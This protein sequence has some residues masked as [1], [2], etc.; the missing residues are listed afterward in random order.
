ME[1][2]W[3]QFYTYIKVL[4]MFRRVKLEVDN[5]SGIS[6][7]SYT[8]WLVECIYNFSIIVMIVDTNYFLSLYL[9]WGLKLKQISTQRLQFIPYNYIIN[10]FIIVLVCINFQSFVASAK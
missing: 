5:Y 2:G 7:A 4:K 1:W 9:R 8:V 10:C 3:S 6:A